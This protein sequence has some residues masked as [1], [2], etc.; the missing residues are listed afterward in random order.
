MILDKTGA[1][2]LAFIRFLFNLAVE[3]SKK[4]EP[5][6]S[7][8][9]LGFHDAIELF[10]QL[11]SEYL[12]VSRKT[13]IGFMEYWDLINNKELSPKGITQKESMR[14]LNRARVEL[15]HNG[16]LL[17]KLDIEGFRVNAADFFEE[18]TPIVFGIQLNDVSLTELVQYKK[19]RDYLKK[20]E[21]ALKQNKREDALDNVAFAFE[22]LIRDY[23]STKIG[24]FGRSIFRF[25]RDMTFMGS[26]SWDFNG[27]MVRNGFRFKGKMR[28][29]VDSVKES[30]EGIQSAVKILSLGI[31]YRRYMKFRL[32]TPVVYLDEY[33]KWEASRDTWGSKGIPT[34]EDVQFCID[35][36]IES[37]ISLQ[38]LDFTLEG[39][40]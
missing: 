31:D 13:E 5:L 38:E 15:K 32:L 34:V 7:A 19:A 23:E 14:R 4:P 26:S 24:K 36:V 30:L 25:G 20:A 28:E 16:I 12:G 6:S 10:L 1:R 11:A 3:Q 2:R 8:S 33:G 9:V 17:S 29:F 22:Q 27:L 39:A 21:K 37:A 35:F 18:N 40:S